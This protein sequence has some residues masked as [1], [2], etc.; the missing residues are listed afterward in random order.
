LAEIKPPLT[1]QLCQSIVV[2]STPD[3]RKFTPASDPAVVTL[4]DLGV[5]GARESALFVK[6]VQRRLSPWIID[7]SDVASS[8]DTTIQ[9]SANSLAQNVQ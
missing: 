1:P 8:P 7:D 3:P 6:A 9:K 5:V 2:Q 4:F